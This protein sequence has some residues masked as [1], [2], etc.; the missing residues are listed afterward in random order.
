MNRSAEDYIDP[1][2]IERELTAIWATINGQQKDGGTV[3]RAS[4]SNVMIFCDGED[5][6]LDAADRIPRLVQH[7]P[8]RVLVLALIEEQAG[9]GV[10]AWVTSHCRRTGDG[11][12]LCAEHIELRFGVGSAARAASIV[13]SLLIS[14][15][16]CA[17]WWLSPRPPALTGAVFDAFAPMAN[18][19]IYDSIGWA[20]PPSGVLAMVRWSK[21]NRTV[22]FN[23]AWRR[24]KPWRRMLSQSL[25]PSALPGA[26]QRID[27]VALH[28]GPHALPLAWL[29]LGW[30]ASRLGWQPK[31]GVAEAGSQLNWRFESPNG[32][33]R[34][35][36][37]RHDDGPPNIDWMRISWQAGDAQP[38]GCAE[39]R[40]EGHHIRHIPSDDSMRPSST[41]AVEQR[42]EQMVAAQ[43]AHRAGDRL[44]TE[45]IAFSE[46][47]AKVV[48][49]ETVAAKKEPNERG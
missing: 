2:E 23:L 46:A 35:T 26:L 7:H 17:L 48:K 27:A 43:L 19:I 41:P 33:V 3:T 21:N 31:Q 16:P 38:A 4:M 30:L 34:I 40:H 15:L 25:D 6:A 28:H 44:F 36:M 1:V 10:Q 24:L 47:M 9:E 32:P 45:S 8:A 18:Q 22:I 12:Q 20:D 14:D 11:Q 29:L 49:G 39:Y 13:R 42:L 5:Q 37:Q